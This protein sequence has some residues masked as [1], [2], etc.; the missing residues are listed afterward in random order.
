MQSS[1]NASMNPDA[2]TRQKVT[3]AVRRSGLVLCVDDDPLN[4][5]L[6]KAL[7]EGLGHVF[8]GA[9]S[10][11]EC[12]RMLETVQPQIILL[13]IMMP[14]MDG[15]E[16]CLRIRQAFND[17]GPRIVY[18]TARNMI[19]DVTHALETGADDYLV[20]PLQMMTL[21]TRLSFW[22]KQPPRGADT[23]APH[24]ETREAVGAE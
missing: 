13:D 10:G 18:V 20:K 3:K 6:S 22:L 23:A 1:A 2:P 8:I 19:E 12:L 14:E 11:E 4:L 24:E 21:D 5:K 17:G 16:T 9:S 7:V 15:F